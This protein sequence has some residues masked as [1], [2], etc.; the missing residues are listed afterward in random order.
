MNADAIVGSAAGQLRIYMADGMGGFTPPNTVVVSGGVA[1]VAIGDFS[2]DQN[3]DV[4][5]A[6]GGVSALTMFLGDGMGNL[7]PPA[8]IDVGATSASAL[9][10]G[11]INGDGDLDIAF[12]DDTTLRVV[13]GNGAL[14]FSDG[15]SIEVGKD[16]LFQALLL[17]D[18]TNDGLDDLVFGRPNDTQLAIFPSN[19]DGTFGE[20]VD[21]ALEHGVR[22]LTHG[23]ANGDGLP[24]LLPSN[25]LFGGVSLLLSNP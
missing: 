1:E 2:G 7:G 6:S 11:D 23:D 8:N 24:D 4:V 18:V 22:E 13:L 14:A 20:R 25:P 19:G 5:V 3:E 15:A 16:Q 12:I 10:I 21:F 9:A 17:V